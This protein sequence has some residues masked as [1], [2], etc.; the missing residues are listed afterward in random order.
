MFPTYSHTLSIKQQAILG[1]AKQYVGLSYCYGGNGPQCIDC[2]GF[3]SQVFASTGFILP[4]T[5]QQQSLIGTPVSS[6]DILPGDL[7]FFSFAGK[8]IEHVGIYAGNGS[9]FHASKSKGVTLQRLDDSG[10]LPGL[11][12]I[13]RISGIM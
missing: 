2:S 11:T 7:L 6:D 10:L 1:K 8:T 12:I 5:A 3:V 13:R 9:M 4:R